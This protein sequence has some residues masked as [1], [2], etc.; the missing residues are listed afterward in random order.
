[1][2]GVT[3][4]YQETVALF[5]AIFGVT[6]PSVGRRTNVN[7][8]KSGAG[9]EIGPE[10]RRAVD[11]FRAEDVEL[12]RQACERFEKLCSKLLD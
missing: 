1:M 7:P 5:G 3:E 6:M 11:R 9:Y 4:R 10:V 8:M 12:Y 2:I